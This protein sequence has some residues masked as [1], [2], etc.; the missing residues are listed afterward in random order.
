M[1]DGSVHSPP[2]L[3]NATQQE[4]FISRL[5]EQGV[6]VTDVKALLQKG[7]TDA[8]KAWLE[9]YFQSSRPA[10]PD[11]SLHSPPDLTNTTQQQEIITRLE[12]RGVNVTEVKTELQA[13]DTEAVK[14]WLES[15]AHAHEG[16]MPF[17]HHPGGAG[18]VNQ[19]GTGQ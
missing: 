2:D 18:P 9:A 6:D 5:D 14:A 12:D 7:D 3:T 15:Y 8:V 11:G 17:R 13:S 4:K 16:D 1:P 10:M 19:I